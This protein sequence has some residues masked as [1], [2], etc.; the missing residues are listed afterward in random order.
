M[1]LNTTGEN[2]MPKQ[3]AFLNNSYEQVL[4]IRAYDSM[5]LIFQSHSSKN[6]LSNWP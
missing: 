1:I 4:E 3:S 5:Q 2:G 6:G